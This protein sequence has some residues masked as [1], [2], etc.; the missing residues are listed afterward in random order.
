MERRFPLKEIYRRGVPSYINFRVPEDPPKELKPQKHRPCKF[1]FQPD[2]TCKRGEDCVFAHSVAELQK[3]VEVCKY[4][5]CFKVKVTESVL[6]Q[7]RE[8]VQSEKTQRQS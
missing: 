5:T 7:K 2:K 8:E 6:E 3:N 4:E 1:A